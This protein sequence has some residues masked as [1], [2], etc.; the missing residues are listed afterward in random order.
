[1]TKIRTW[2]DKHKR[3][4]AVLA[5]K[6]W[7]ALFIV[8][9]VLIALLSTMLYIATWFF[10]TL[11]VCTLSEDAFKRL[12]L[13]LAELRQFIDM[14]YKPTFATGVLAFAGFLIDS[15]GDKIPDVLQKG[16]GN[17]V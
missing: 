17:N 9:I 12:M 4:K 6:G 15:N 10:T 1:M 13:L 2:L 14:L 16:G 8:L 11:N 5:W 7:A 3:L